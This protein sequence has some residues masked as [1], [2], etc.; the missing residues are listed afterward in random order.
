MGALSSPRLRLAVL[1]VVLVAAAVA[2]A[3]YGAPGL[4]RIR[5]AVQRGGPAAPI[6]FVAL[7]V[8]VV[9]LMVP[10]TPVT[11][12][13][14]ALFGTALGFALSLTGATLGAT[15]AFLLGRRLGREQV[16][17]LAGRRARELDAHLARSGFVSV[18][19]VR[20]VPIFP[21]GLVSY[22]AG[23][24]GVRARAY[25]P[26][27]VLGTIPAALAYSAVGGESA[28]PDS[29]AFIAAVAGLAALLGG[30]ALLAR[31]LRSR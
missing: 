13:G 18:L 30:G 7:Y 11:L 4:E 19:V 24:T 31:R 1:L 5:E 29:P 21:Y 12:A 28:R 22:G 27:T 3:L 23:L 16:E 17:G 25:V 14:G 26:A 6:A 2:G 8:L 20:L 9:A 10:A 15:L